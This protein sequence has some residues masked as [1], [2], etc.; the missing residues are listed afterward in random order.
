MVF[1]NVPNLIIFKGKSGTW[2]AN[3]ISMR[4]RYLDVYW[5][6]LSFILVAAVRKLSDNCLI[7]SSINCARSRE[8]EGKILAELMLKIA[9]PLT[10]LPITPGRIKTWVLRRVERGG[11]AWNHARHAAEEAY[12]R[13][14]TEKHPVSARGSANPV[15]VWDQEWTIGEE[16]FG[17]MIN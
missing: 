1:I 16:S 3:A 7:A 14:V 12:T 9:D 15:A 4:C 13:D 6:W 10:N 11:V 2:F 17:Y 8:R 5:G